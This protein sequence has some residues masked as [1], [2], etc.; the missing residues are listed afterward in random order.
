MNSFTL[1]ACLVSEHFVSG[2][3][4]FGGFRAAMPQ[5][6]GVPLDLSRQPAGASLGLKRRLLDHPSMKAFRPATPEALTPPRT[7]RQ[8][9]RAARR[10]SAHMLH[11]RCF[12]MSTG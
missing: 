10:R 5:A 1:L 4:H 9:S 2:G 6:H 12:E 11:R 8:C 3:E 7:R